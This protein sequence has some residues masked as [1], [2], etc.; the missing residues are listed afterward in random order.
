MDLSFDELPHSTDE[1]FLARTSRRPRF[2]DRT[3]LI[4]AEQTRLLYEQAPTSF[5]VT[6]LNAGILTFVLRDVVPTPR[7]FVW[8]GFIMAVTLGRILL[9]WRYRLA[10]P[11]VEQATFWRNLFI[12]GAAGAGI[13][14]GLAGVLLFAPDSLGHQI[15][16]AFVLGGMMTGAVAI[17]SW[18][19]IAFL[20]FLAPAATPIIAQF[21]LQGGD[22]F[23]AMGALSVTFTVALLTMSRHLHSSVTE[24]L[25]LRFDKVDLIR[26]LS[27]SESQT[28]A[29][30]IALREEVA[31]RIRA[32]TELRA[33]RDKL[34]ERVRERTAELGATNAALL[35]AK[36]AAE[37]AN[38]AKGEFLA[39][40][41]HELRTPLNVIIGYADLL[42]EHAFG[43]LTEEQTNTMKRVKRSAHELYE[44]IS[45]M[46]DLSRLEA[47]R[48]PVDVRDVRLHDFLGELRDET[49]EIQEQSGLQFLWT[50]EPCLPF[51]RTDPAKLKV[52]VKNLL[53]NAIRFTTKGSITVDA[54]A[55]QGGVEIA[56]TDT[57]VGIPQES[58]SLIFEPFQQI[59]NLES[60]Q[61][62][63]TG[64]GLHI[65]KRLLGLLDGHITVESEEGRGSTFRI[66]IPTKRSEVEL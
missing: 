64:L 16:L 2:H 45:A 25:S 7:L 26:D 24:S 39:T 60:R 38:R 54:R 62:G 42:S 56:V 5:V 3:V 51:V 28:A 33:S 44:L 8:F 18:V 47:G 34:E 31:E 29:V 49:R 32:E 12:V 53:R 59:D 22:L 61:D 6:L 50:I 10:E 63:G 40:M 35:E 21:F 23:L 30:N 66:W 37:G 17:L 11:S 57:G 1:S 48:L 15:F 43:T 19:K 58:L 13:A 55:A 52:I 46:L 4:A 14:W 65:V 36:D 20:V 9:A 41:S 27:A